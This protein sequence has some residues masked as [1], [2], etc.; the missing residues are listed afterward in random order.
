V[1]LEIL[2]LDLGG[3]CR[4][5]GGSMFNATK[6]VNIATLDGKSNILEGPQI[7]GP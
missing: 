3:K 2:G 4:W 1:S 6:K 5:N 7:D